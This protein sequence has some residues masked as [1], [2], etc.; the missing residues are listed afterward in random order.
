MFCPSQQRVYS[1]REGIQ[2]AFA[3]IFRSFT[4]ESLTKRVSI[5]TERRSGV[6][7]RTT[8]TTKESGVSANGAVY[9]GIAHTYWV[10][11]ELWPQTAYCVTKETDVF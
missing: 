10:Q 3:A 7:L 5:E 1:L 8:L 6:L 11:N 9:T 2:M 4:K